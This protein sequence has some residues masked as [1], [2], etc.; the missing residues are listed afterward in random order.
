MRALR[1]ETIY[2]AVIHYEADV[3]VSNEIQDRA[4]IMARKSS[5]S[6]G[7]K[8]E[9]EV[10]SFRGDAA[11]SPYLTGVGDNL[12]AVTQWAEKVERYINRRKGAVLI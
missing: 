2:R 11:C 6:S 8:I 3:D 5:S 12:R 1:I 10:E 9:V 4:F 7:R